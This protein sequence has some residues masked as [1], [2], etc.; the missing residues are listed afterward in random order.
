MILYCL[1]FCFVQ[2]LLLSSVNQLLTLFLK[3]DI[4]VG[5]EESKDTGAMFYQ[6]SLLPIQVYVPSPKSPFFNLFLFHFFD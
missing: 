5:L 3:M 2:F 4:A 1:F 6:M